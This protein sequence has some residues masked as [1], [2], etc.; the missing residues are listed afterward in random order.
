MWTAVTEQFG[1][2]KYGVLD[3]FSGVE[4]MNAECLASLLLVPSVSDAVT[5]MGGLTRHG[6]RSH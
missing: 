6:S 2:A 3:A 1:G 4:E 5:T